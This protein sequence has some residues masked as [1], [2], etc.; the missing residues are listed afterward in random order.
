MSDATVIVVLGASGGVGASVLTAALAVRASRAGRDPVVVDLRPLRGGLDIIFGV[1]QDSGLRW[2][3]LQELQ[4]HADAAAI[5][6]RLPRADGVPV[7]SVGRED[8][9][10]PD[11]QVV[12]AVLT[13]LAEAEELLV[14]DLTLESG[15]ADL[16]IELA[17]LVVVVAGTELGQLAALSS[18]GLWLR[19]RGVPIAVCLRGDKRATAFRELVESTMGLPVEGLIR[20]DPSIRADLA[21]GVPPGGRGSGSLTA[22][23][24]ALLARAC[25][26]REG[27]A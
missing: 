23:A 2:A 14:I 27:A 18:L 8:A 22:T 3:D 7:L 1:E 5:V 12:G 16:V 19:A 9:A 26:N 4:G 24:D 20:D 6:E 25:P 21:H 13:S 17:S 10:L 15:I 11:A